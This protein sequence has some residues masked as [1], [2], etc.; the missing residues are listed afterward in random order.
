[1]CIEVDSEFGREE[2]RTATGRVVRREEGRG[3][4]KKE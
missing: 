2:G 3:M 1:V 4:G